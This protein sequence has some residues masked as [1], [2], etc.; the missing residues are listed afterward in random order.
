MCFHQLYSPIQ[1]DKDH[2]LYNFIYMYY[3]SFS[4]GPNSFVHMCVWC[5]VPDSNYMLNWTGTSKVRS[6]KV[7]TFY[8]T[9]NKLNFGW[10]YGAAVDSSVA[11]CLW[12]LGSSV[13]QCT[14]W[15]ISSTLLSAWT[16][17]EIT[18]RA[19]AV[20]I[21]SPYCHGVVSRYSAFPP[22][23]KNMLR[24]IGDFPTMW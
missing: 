8:L 16:H 14:V 20:C 12:H 22:Q 10:C 24:W 11:L 5:G 4:V 2:N 13:R 6:S 19:C 17:S 23:S 9:S 3:G 18:S 21:Y 1:M 15:L 7:N